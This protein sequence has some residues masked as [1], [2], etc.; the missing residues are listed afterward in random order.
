MKANTLEAGEGPTWHR[1]AS[2]RAKLGST[3][4]ERRGPSW[5]RQPAEFAR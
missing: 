2:T 5:G 3:G 4:Q 1:A